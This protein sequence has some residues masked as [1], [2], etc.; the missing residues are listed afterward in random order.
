[1]KEIVVISGKGGAG[2]TSFSAAFAI[3]AG[4]DAVLADC[5]VDASDLHLLLRPDFAESKD[6]YSGEKAEIDPDMCNMCGACAD[7][8]RFD[9]IW[10]GETTFAVSRVDCEGCAYCQKVCPEYAITMKTQKAGEYYISKAKTGASMVHA[11]LEAGAENSG[12]LVA[13]VK[14]KAKE[15]A[16]NENKNIIIVDG[17]PGIGCPTIS[18]LS[19][20]NYVVL[21]AEPTVSGVHDLKR[22]V[23][24]AQ[25][26]K[27]D[28]GCLIN[29]SD[30]NPE[31]TAEIL[32]FLA[33]SNV[34]YLGDTL[35]DETFTKAMVEGKTVVEYDDGKLKESIVNIWNVIKQYAI[36]D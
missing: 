11:R 14:N 21:V 10:E 15:I 4:R 20:A 2:K 17:S 12:K 35:Y 9:A 31:K 32:N 16:K 25:R 22:A 8:C 3:L 18:S 27:I 36:G 7:V 1:M 5:D 29:K 6:F 28:C 13:Q 24:L 34:R 23:E 33:N 30:I 26:F 19:G